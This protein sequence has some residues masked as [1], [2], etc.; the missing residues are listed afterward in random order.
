MKSPHAEI[1]KYRSFTL[2]FGDELNIRRT[3][4]EK[5][6]SLIE[7][8]LSLWTLITFL[9]LACSSLTPQVGRL[10]CGRSIIMGRTTNI[11]LLSAF[12][13]STTCIAQLQNIIFFAKSNCLDGSYV[14]CFKFPRD[15]CC[16]GAI[17]GRLGVS[18]SKGPY[19]FGNAYNGGACTNLV[20][21]GVFTI[22]VPQKSLCRLLY[23]FD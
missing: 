22:Q 6:Q 15:T 1:H 18:I 10:L 19:D 16:G 17:T 3:A 2:A 23:D 8:L 14:G 5:G 11:L 13:L 9:R 12:L 7:I 21:V 4:F 20:C